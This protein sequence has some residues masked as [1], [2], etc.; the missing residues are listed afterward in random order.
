MLLGITH[1]CNTGWKVSIMK[2][3]CKIK[4]HILNFDIYREL[5]GSNNSYFFAI[6]SILIVFGV[7]CFQQ[8]FPSKLW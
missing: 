2:L 8:F 7:V 3:L 4:S 1:F 6:E 5:W